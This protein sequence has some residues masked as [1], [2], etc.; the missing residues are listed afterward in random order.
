M[1]SIAVVGSINVDLVVETDIS[2]KMGQ[3]ILGNNFFMSPGGKGANQAVAAAR[4]GRN[5]CIFGSLGRDE[6]GTKMKFNLQ[7]EGIEIKHINYVENVPTGVAV[8]ELCNNDNRIIVVP[9]ANNFTNI[10]YLEKVKEE[11][12]SFDVIVMQMEIPIEAIEYIVN[13]L[14]ENKK[15]IVL[16][17]APA[18]PLNKELI[19]KVTYITPNEHEYKIILNT[20]EDMEEALRRYPNKLI[21]TQGEQGVK[22][23]DGANI[24]TV[25]C[26]KVEAIDTTGAGDTF[27]GAFS[28]AISEGKSL[29]ESISFA[30]I[31]AGISVT[32]KGAQGGMPNREA[33]DRVFNIT[34][35]K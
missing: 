26:I 10:T 8:I 24:I 21:I 16:N 9:G 19:E 6:N 35:E 14:H 15:T 4:L 7:K 1:N 28:V 31:A 13:F 20:E 12:L 27:S 22:Y 30:N 33:V 34:E 17:P 18:L 23:F 32:Q 25:P 2:P 5:I 11:L 29:F 3:T